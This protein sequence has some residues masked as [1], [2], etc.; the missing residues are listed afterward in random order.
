MSACRFSANVRCLLPASPVDRHRLS[1]GDH[2]ADRQ[3]RATGDIAAADACCWPVS[4]C[5]RWPPGYAVQGLGAAIMM[6]LTMAFVSETVPKARTGSAVWGSRNDV[7]DRHR[8]R[9]IIGRRLD[10]RPRLAGRLPRHDDPA[11]LHSLLAWCDPAGLLLPAMQEFRERTQRCREQNDR[12][13]MLV[14]A[15]LQGV[16]RTLNVLD[17]GAQEGQTYGPG[18]DNTPGHGR[19]VAT[20]A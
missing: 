19:V 18:S 14:N 12:N 9:A 5:S 7:G 3:R 2:H 10:H 8:A 15:R 17:R 16:S 4:S 20:R 13:G 6:A 11:G 1:P